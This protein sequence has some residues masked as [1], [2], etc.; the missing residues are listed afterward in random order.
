MKQKFHYTTNFNAQPQLLANC[1]HAALRF[2]FKS[3]KVCYVRMCSYLLC[4]VLEMCTKEW[5]AGQCRCVGV[6]CE[7]FSS[8][9][10]GHQHCQL[11][12]C[13][14]KHQALKAA[15][16][17]FLD[18]TQKC[19]YVIILVGECLREAGFFKSLLSLLIWNKNE[20]IFFRK[21]SVGLNRFNFF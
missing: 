11:P 13:Q 14:K 15:V 8:L 7:H 5:F 21:G 9:F 19:L 10:T 16:F 4:L 3:C 18:K 1:A 17:F 12:E 2:L 20:V 6:W